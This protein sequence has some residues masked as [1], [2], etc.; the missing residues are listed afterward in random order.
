[1]CICTFHTNPPKPLADERANALIGKHL[2]H[3]NLRWPTIGVNASL[4]CMHVIHARGQRLE[5]TMWA[6]K[7]SNTPL[8][9]NCAFLWQTQLI[10]SNL[11]RNL[12]TNPLLLSWPALCQPFRALKAS[13]T[14]RSPNHALPTSPTMC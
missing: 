12:L 10:I 14:I 6:P 4:K 7:P 2:I 3:L 9:F 1:M 13:P 11:A 5:L 8:G